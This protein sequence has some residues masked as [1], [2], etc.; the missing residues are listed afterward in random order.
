MTLESG[1]L[2][3]P[4]LCFLKGAQI[5]ISINNY[6]TQYWWKSGSVPGFAQR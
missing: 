6:T 3:V 5:P 4:G 1:H 2:A